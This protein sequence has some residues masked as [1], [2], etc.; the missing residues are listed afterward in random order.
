MGANTGRRYSL[1]PC[2]GYD[3]HTSLS[4]DG[5]IGPSPSSPGERITFVRRFAAGPLRFAR[6][7]VT[8]PF[9]AGADVDSRKRTPWIEQAHSQFHGTYG[10]QPDELQRSKTVVSSIT[11]SANWRAVG[12]CGDIRLW[13]R[14]VRQ[15]PPKLKRQTNPLVMVC[16]SLPKEIVRDG[17]VEDPVFMSSGSLMPLQY[18]KY[19]YSVRQNSPFNGT[20]SPRAYSV[21]P[22]QK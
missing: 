17:L 6:F 16:S 20:I 22:P 1:P 2:G 11:A 8:A 19:R 4:A 9:R 18:S 13:N 10:S 3:I 21:P 14:R 12:K 15:G 5:H 7:A